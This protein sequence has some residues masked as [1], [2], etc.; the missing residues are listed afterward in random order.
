[1]E[2]TFK[3]TPAEGKVF[4]DKRT[5]TTYSEVRCTE[6]DFKKFFIEVK[7]NEVE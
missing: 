6:E 3:Y 5:R 7:A 1:M 2:K 4:L